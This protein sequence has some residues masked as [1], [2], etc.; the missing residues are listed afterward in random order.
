MDTSVEYLIGF[1]E[2]EFRDHP[3]VRIKPAPKVI[4]RR[5]PDLVQDATPEEIEHLT[6]KGVTVKTPSR[7]YFFPSTWV[8]RQ[9][10]SAIHALVEKVRN[11]LQR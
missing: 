2:D 5:S 9:E 6:V 10:Y 11:D 8:K 4:A 7:E 3:E 1:L